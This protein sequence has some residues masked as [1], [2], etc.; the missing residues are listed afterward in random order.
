MYFISFDVATKSLAV[1]IIEYNI[2]YLDDIE[3]AII[4]YHK[5]KPNL[6]GS[7]NINKLLEAYICLLDQTKKIFDTK[8]K[9]IDLRVKDLI[10]GK[11]LSETTIVERTSALYKYL[12]E[13]DQKIA[14]LNLEPKDILFLIEYQMGPNDKS[15][16]ISSQIMYHFTKFATTIDSEP[17]IQ[18]VGP[19]LKNKIIIG[20]LD[21]N[22]SEFLEKY[23]CNYTANKNHAKY[24]FI[25]L[26]KYLD[27]EHMINGIRK[28]NID[29]I[30]D[31][32]LMS[33]AY[34]LKKY[35]SIKH[36]DKY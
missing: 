28:K 35:P 15:R 27:V 26:I 18:L 14:D 4:E 17:N 22:Y 2:N 12:C 3:A 34:R 23:S 11:K 30:A 33:L 10:P 31:S 1:S 6:Q 16:V 8:M 19:S 7:K 24:N 29:D 9:I 25:K 13:I 21:S 5:N 20:G 32:V 36:Y